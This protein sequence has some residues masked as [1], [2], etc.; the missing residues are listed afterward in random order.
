[1]TNKCILDSRRKGG[2]ASCQDRFCAHRIAMH[3]LNGK[4][5]RVG[6]A[7]APSDYKYLTLGNSP[8]RDGMEKLYRTLEAYVKTFN[9]QF[10]E[11]GERIKSWYFYSTNPG[12]GKTTT[13]IALMNEFIMSNYLGALS[14]GEQPVQLPAMFFDLNQVQRTYNLASQ[15]DDKEAIKEIT[16]KFDKAA[17]V[18]FL[19][20]DDVG[21][22]SASDAFKGMLHDVINHRA[23]NSLPTVYTSNVS[24]DEFI[25]IYDARVYDRARDKCQEIKFVGESKRGK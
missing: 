23:T 17:R 10:D 7:G 15:A 5:G 14:R 19:V 3:G 25:R 9:R 20:L 22:R 4:G 11:D 2:C 21:I 12:T 6:A 24:L 18:P 8:A 1:M 16:Q 13:A